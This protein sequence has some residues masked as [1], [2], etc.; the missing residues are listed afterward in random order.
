[1]FVFVH[2][3]H[4]HLEVVIS[5]PL[6]GFFPTSEFINN[7]CKTGRGV[8]MLY[9]SCGSCLQVSIFKMIVCLRFKNTMLQSIFGDI[10]YFIQR[11]KK[12][13][14]VQ[15]FIRG[16]VTI[17][18]FKTKKPGRER[19]FLEEIFLL[20]LAGKIWGFFLFNQWRLLCCR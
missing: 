5:T 17:L 3:I 13:L 2:N 18:C 6:L 7:H 15:H 10:S 4:Q 1:M 19:K 8:G 9:V 16:L 14:P 20:R 11:L 12:E